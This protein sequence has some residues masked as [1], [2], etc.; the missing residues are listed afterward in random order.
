[1]VSPVSSMSY[2]WLPAASLLAST[3]LLARSVARTPHW[4]LWTALSWMYHW[5]GGGAVIEVPGAAPAKAQ[6][7]AGMLHIRIPNRLAATVLRA[8]ST[9]GLL[10][11]IP[12]T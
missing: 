8:S 12:V 10:T 9:E 2:T 1:M 3:L 6:V 4:L 11:L 7:S 5:D